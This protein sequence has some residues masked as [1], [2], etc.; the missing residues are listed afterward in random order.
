MTIN[1]LRIASKALSLV[2]ATILML[3]YAAPTQ[4]NQVGN[5]E[6]IKVVSAVITSEFPEGFRINVEVS[7]ENEI[8]SVAVQ[9][10]IGRQTRGAYDYLCQ[11][12]EPIA[13]T[14][15]RCNDLE[16][17]QT[18]DGELFW[19]TDTPGRYIPPGTVITYSFEIEDSEGAEL[20]TEEEEFTYYDVRFEWNEVSDGAVTVAYHGPVKTRAE[21]VLNAILETLANIGPVLGAD[22]EEPIR[23]TMYNNTREMLDALPFGSAAISRELITEGQA[24][25]QVGT[26]LV[27]G[28]GRLAK[29][30][31]SHEVTHIVV[32][33]AGDGIFRRVPPWL[34]EGLAEFAN[35]DPGF[36]YDIALDFAVATGRLLPITHMTNLPGDPE[37]VII[38][39][40]QAR[41]I[42]RFMIQT[43]GAEKM[44]DLMAAHKADMSTADAIQELYEVTIVE[45]D[46]LWRKSIGAPPYIPPETGGVRPTPAPRRA[47]LP[48]SL[49][50]QPDAETIGDKSDE[51]TL[52]PEPTATATLVS[53]TATSAPAAAAAPAQESEPEEPA[54]VGGGCTA[55]LHGG[56][57]AQ[58]VALVGLLLGLVGMGLG[59]RGKKEVRVKGK[60][61]DPPR[62]FGQV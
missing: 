28:G 44:S 18:V 57:Q 37:D 34:N 40:G 61:G 10:R 51:P 48:Y 58:D 23:V 35:I 33:R 41:S 52:T 30:T 16:I 45:L 1:T 14:E 54:A 47:I 22:I 56:S 55:P 3:W 11:R 4:A 25:S 19:R 59:R 21:I 46:N 7:G 2:L 5:S 6:S 15:W 62:P 31:A 24:F 42:V 12:V 49:T 36:S 9:L 38:F 17:A 26:L 29:G 53:P 32:H 13:A 43:Y 8:A 50:P 60:K 39:Y 20:K 27:L